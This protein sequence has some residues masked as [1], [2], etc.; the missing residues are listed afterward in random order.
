MVRLSIRNEVNNLSVC[1]KTAPVTR[2]QPGNPAGHPAGHQYTYSSVPH[3]LGPNRQ[4]W[5]VVM[6]MI[7]LHMHVGFV[8]YIVIIAIIH[9]HSTN[10]GKYSI[11]LCIKS[12]LLAEVSHDE[13]KLKE[14]RETSAGF[15]RVV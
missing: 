2:H 8:Y 11:V 7:H 4:E 14:R 10:A 13:A 15:R 3:S 1:Y 5:L 12:S 6:I 9:L